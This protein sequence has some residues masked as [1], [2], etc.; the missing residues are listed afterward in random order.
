VENGWRVAGGSVESNRAYLYSDIRLKRLI[1][2][3]FN[4]RLNWYVEEFYV[5]RDPERP[6]LELELQPTKWPVW[7]SLLGAPAYAKGEAELGAALSLGLRPW[8]Y[9]R[10][11]WLKPDYYYNHKNEFN[12][13]YYLQAPNQISVETAYRLGQHYKLRLIWYDNK[14]QEFVLDNQFSVFAYANSNYQGSLD[15]Q[16]DPSRI[17]GV[18]VRG[19][20]TQQSRDDIVTK[21]TQDIRY[22]SVN[23]YWIRTLENNR[24]RTIGLRFDDF[25]NME[26]TPY[27]SSTE[28][29]FLFKTTQIYAEFYQPF[30]PHQAWELGVYLGDATKQ[31]NYLNASLPDSRLNSIEA[32]LR[33]GW[34]IFSIDNA[35]ALTLA[36][37]WNLDDLIHNSFDGGSARFRTEF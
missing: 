1:T 16:E 35:T 9:F 17:L 36:L 6:L 31:R 19:F 22:F 33:T 7:V 3:R 20:S 5:P 12:D 15:Y 29:D 21:R 2:P 32:M 23:A 25:R 11:A 10:I 13:S 8:N 28:F 14:P 18:T 26:R 4:A 27:D 24:E 34:D 37:S 30:T